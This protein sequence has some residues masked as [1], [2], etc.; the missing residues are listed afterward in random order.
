MEAGGAW[1]SQSA[2]FHITPRRYAIE[3]TSVEQAVTITAIGA[4]TAFALLTGLLLLLVMSG[5]AVSYLRN[6]AQVR[7]ERR[8]RELN[9][10]ATAAVVAVGV[11]RSIRRPA[12]G[13]GHGRESA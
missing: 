9:D 3:Q 1:A 11:L 2:L 6:R 7:A 8:R 13:A 12:P 4:G 5:P 10:R